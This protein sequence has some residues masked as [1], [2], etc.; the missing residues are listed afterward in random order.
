M[1]KKLAIIGLAVYVV[2]FG[3]SYALFA[4]ALNG[5][6]TVKP[7][8]E[9][10]GR[11]VFDEDAP[12]TE[13]CP[14][15]GEMYSKQQRQ[16]WEDH[17]PL[18]VMVEN[19]TEARPQSGMSYSDVV[20]EAVAEGGITRFLA[21][22][23][24]Q[25]AGTVGPIRS[26]RIY[27]MHFLAEY[28]DYPLYAHVGGAN[29]NES[30]GAGCANGAP[31]DALGRIREWGWD[32]YNDMDQ[33]GVHDLTYRKIQGKL[34]RADGSPVATEHSMYS[35]TGKLW[36]YAEEERDLTNEDKG[37]NDWSENFVEYSFADDPEV[38]QR[39]NS[40]TI[41]FN[42]WGDAAYAVEWNYDTQTNSYLRENGGEAHTDLE[43]D[44]QLAAKNVVILFMAESPAND[45]YPGN[46]RRV[47]DT[48]GTG[49]ALVFQNGE[50]IQASWSKDDVTSRLM[51][52]DE[53]GDNISFTR[54][55]IWFTLLD[56]STNVS[57]Q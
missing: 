19:H 3:L 42:F 22:F 11:L 41:S 5:G 28:G 36:E 18:G 54:G 45:G 20:Y 17:R 25:D 46:V 56:P 7:P 32:Y 15:N 33:F 52:T 26:A 14:L 27:F 50:Q 16:W 12:K 47:F 39:P 31:A 48:T 24:C 53:N 9:R 30:T 21:V 38:S 37:G 2:C 1:G 40:Q 34:T 10:D 4:Y 43:N 57:V 49:D 51:L 6:V 23:H 35:D 55:R 8:E 13:E 29:C 44:E